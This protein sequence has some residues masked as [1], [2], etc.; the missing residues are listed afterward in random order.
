[1]L[2][3]PQ[4]A[5]V[6]LEGKRTLSQFQWETQ[7][8]RVTKVHVVSLDQRVLLVSKESKGHKEMKENQAQLG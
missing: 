7:V 2:F 6:L 5:R 4:E 3:T 1:M 8:R